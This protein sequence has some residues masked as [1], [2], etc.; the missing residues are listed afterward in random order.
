MMLRPTRLAPWALLAPLLLGG[1]PPKP[2]GV[3]PIPTTRAIPPGGE[4]T[5]ASHPKV[6]LRSD[7]AATLYWSTDGRTPFPGRGNTSS[8]RSPVSGIDILTDTRLEF[9]AVDDEGN[10]EAVRTEI[11]AI[12]QPALTV[13]SPP[14]GNFNQ[15]ITVT[16]QTDKPATIY[17]AFNRD[18]STTDFDLQGQSEIPA[19]SISTEGTTELHYFSID[20]RGDVEDVRTQVYRIDT[21]PPRTTPSPGPTCN[22]NQNA[23]L[24]P[25]RYR[26]PVSVSLLTNEPATLYYTTDGSDPSTSPYASVASGGGTVQGESPITGITISRHTT[27]KFFGVDAVGNQEVTQAADYRIGPSPYTKATPRSGLFNARPVSVALAADLPSTIYWSLTDGSGSSTPFVPYA[28]PVTIWS[29]GTNVLD[30]YAVATTGGY[31]EYTHSEVYTIDTTPPNSVANPPG[32]TYSEP[33]TVSMSTNEPSTL[34]YSIDGGDPDVGKTNT[35]AAPSPA[36]VTISR[37][38]VLKFFAVDTAGNRELGY[39]HVNTYD[40][41]GLYDEIFASTTYEDSNNT[42]ASWGGGKF[43]LPRGNPKVEGVI[44]TPGATGGVALYGNVAY[45]A[46]GANGLVV[47]DVSLPDHPVVVLD[48]GSAPVLA[49]GAPYTDVAAAGHYLYTASAARL[50]VWNIS[51]PKSPKLVGE[52]VNPNP[53]ANFSSLALWGHYA[54]LGDRTAGAQGLGLILVD[55]SNP[56]SPTQ[57]AAGSFTRIQGIN[58]V[59]VAGGVAFLAVSTSGGMGAVDVSQLASVGNNAPCAVGN[60]G[61][62]GVDVR[63]SSNRAYVALA[64]GSL[65]V[66]D[67]AHLG[68]ASGACSAAQHIAGG[69]VA[70]SPQA[71]NALSIEGRVAYVAAADRTLRV[72]DVSLPGFPLLGSIPGAGNLSILV[73]RGEDLFAGRTND[74]GGGLLDVR[75]RDPYQPTQRGTYAV[76][77]PRA[78]VAATNYALLVTGTGLVALDLTDPANPQTATSI[79]LGEAHGIGLYGTYAVVA[80]GTSG[81]AVFDASNPSAPTGPVGGLNTADALALDL[82]GPTALV[83]DGAQGLKIVDLTFPLAPGL[84]AAYATGTISMNSVLSNGAT[85]YASD[86]QS[87][88]IFDLTSPAAPVESAPPVPL[89]GGTVGALA[90]YGSALYAADANRVQVL[91]IGSTGALSFGSN[92]GMNDAQGAATYGEACYVADAGSGL[93]VLDLSTETSPALVRSLGG[94]T[95]QGV[96]LWGD[97]AFLA[98]PARGIEI[99]QVLNSRTNFTSPAQGQSLTV[100]TTSLTIATGELQPIDCTGVPLVPPGEGGVQYWLSADGGNDWESATPFVE[101]AFAKP[102]SDLRWKAT[103]T[104]LDPT[105]SPCLSELRIKYR[106]SE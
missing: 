49:Q 97:Y 8:G 72:F 23:C 83:A 79:P 61:A 25:D 18:P 3:P 53:A 31:T 11:Y 82:W 54:L 5:F 24:P 26:D 50:R 77:N 94:I 20:P 75:I 16:L 58:R 62:N 68:L 85:A 65:D 34:Y 28:G 29:E 84:V 13:A 106:F 92:V 64:N 41:F 98:D 36:T 95:P 104:T 86:A 1:C 70:V 89:Q 78:V 12:I 56:S 40:I 10:E 9:F 45:L 17:A 81:L 4:Y 87:V 90:A 14:G 88:R 38:T 73:H 6:T 42:T 37:D 21:T 63:V 46:D 22:P 66:Y 100:N 48:R 19:I 102:G 2:Q 74:P 15:P 71:L 43:Q 76:A 32:G 55:V 103:L 59:R 44:S 51:S 39:P 93:K 57:P 27:L 7:K 33:Q 91:Q 35:V 99:V 67:I 47:V 105:R 80:S 60:S 96:F 69:A 101:H 52:Y 30:F